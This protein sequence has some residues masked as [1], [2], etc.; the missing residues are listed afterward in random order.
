[1]KIYLVCEENSAGYTVR[2]LRSCPEAAHKKAKELTEAAEEEYMQ[3]CMKWYK[4]TPEKAKD[5]AMERMN[6]VFFVLTLELDAE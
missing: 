2:C 3:N 5:V 1:M 6:G 4:Y